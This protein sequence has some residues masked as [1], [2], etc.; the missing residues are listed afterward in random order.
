MISPLGRYKR[1]HFLVPTASL[2]ILGRVKFPSHAAQAPAPTGEI[3][4]GGKKTISIFHS[5]SALNRLDARFVR[6]YITKV[7][8]KIFSKRIFHFY[9]L[10]L[11]L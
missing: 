11:C 1:S 6:V 4:I 3:E 9:V 2:F 8:N 10:F 7:V 5:L